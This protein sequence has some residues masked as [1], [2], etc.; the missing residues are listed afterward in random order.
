MPATAGS[1][2]AA[3]I[4]AAA[5]NASACRDKSIR[6]QL[7]RMVVSAVKE[8][9][10]QSHVTILRGASKGSESHG[11]TARSL[12]HDR[13]KPNSAHVM[14]SREDFANRLGLGHAGEP[15]IEAVVEE[16]QPAVIETHRVKDGGV[17]V[18]DVA[19]IDDSL[20]PDLV[21][22]AVTHAPLD[23]A[24]GQPVGKPFGIVIAALGSLR[25]GLAAE[26]ASPDDQR[27]IEESALLEVG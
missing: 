25:N 19:A 6:T 2:D 10:C 13:F 4:V 18:A 3:S 8:R 12:M 27:L 7:L 11:K 5:M 15:L 16:C 26:L 14:A 20:V 22:L 1:A 21:G 9:S 23:S 24:A 17:Q